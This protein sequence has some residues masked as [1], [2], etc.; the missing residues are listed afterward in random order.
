MKSAS[1]L[2][3]VAVRD[4]VFVLLLASR[5][6][7]VFASDTLELI[8]SRDVLRWGADAE[9]GAALRADIVAGDKGLGSV[10]PGGRARRRID[11]GGKVV[12]ATVTGLCSRRGS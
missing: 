7:P 11:L 5:P 4:F 8:R 10:E 2:S 12:A 1:R 9:G 6:L 3:R